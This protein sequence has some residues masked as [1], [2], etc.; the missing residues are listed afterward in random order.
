MG[1]LRRLLGLLRTADEAGERLPTSG[2]RDLRELADRV[3]QGGLDVQ[4]DVVGE[5]RE[6]PP[7]IDLSA[8]RIVQEALTNT[9]KHAS[10]RR[11]TVTVRYGERDMELEV[12]DDGVAAAASNGSGHG[13]NGL[14]ERAAL[15]G[16]TLDAAPQPAGGF[17]VYAA[18][19]LELPGA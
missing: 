8:F 19:P 1:E 7:G 14:R 9:L 13:L 12:V 5:P 11:A 18:L 4:L 16:G 3:R 17:R 6:L 15:Y 2:L 10:A